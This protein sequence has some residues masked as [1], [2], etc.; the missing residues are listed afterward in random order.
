MS[1]SRTREMLG[2][3]VSDLSDEE[4]QQLIDDMRRVC[5]Y[6]L[7]TISHQIKSNKLRV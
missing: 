4:V 2:Q 3:E 1:V 7:E 5:G 6:A